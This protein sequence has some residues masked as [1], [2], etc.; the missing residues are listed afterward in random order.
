MKIVAQMDD[1]SSINF[2]FDSTFAT[3]LEAQNRGHEIYYYLP[4]NLSLEGNKITTTL[5]KLKLQNKIGNHYQILESKIVNLAEKSA[6]ID[7]LLIRQDPPFDMNYLTSTYILEKLRGKIL[8][9]ND[10]T[11]IRNCPEKIFVTEF[12]EFMPPTMITADLEAAKN[13]RKKHGDI[14][15]KPLYGHA[16]SDVLLIKEEDKNLATLFE[17]MLKLQKTPIIIQKFLPKVKDGD[18]RILFLDGKVVGFFN[19]IPMKGEVRSNIAL[20][21]TA[22]ETELTNQEKKI[23][24]KLGKELKKQGLVFAGIDVIDEQITEIN[25]TS[26]TGIIAANKLNK[27]KIEALI[28]DYLEKHSK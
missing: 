24:H 15:I 20:G 8:F 26:P 3:L 7:V 2:S 14:V 25:V 13:F 27:T 23:C 28:I 21:G 19:R 9:I 22:V 18:K 4:K 6:K 12:S 17:I 1:I 11:G 16:G 10:P 5:H